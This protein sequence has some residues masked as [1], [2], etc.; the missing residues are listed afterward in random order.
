MDSFLTLLFGF[1]GSNEQQVVEQQ[2]IEDIEIQDEDT[3]AG[4]KGNNGC[5]I[6]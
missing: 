1:T 4:S 5:V 2:V 3:N 6:A